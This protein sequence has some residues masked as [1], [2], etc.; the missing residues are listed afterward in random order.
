MA[1]TPGDKNPRYG[2]MWWLNPDYSYMAVGAG[3][4]YIWIDPEHDLVIVLRWI[5]GAT[6]YL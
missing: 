4:N 6:I 2:Y 1:T 5:D 3:G